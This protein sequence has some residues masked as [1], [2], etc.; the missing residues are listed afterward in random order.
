MGRRNVRV[1]VVVTLGIVLAMTGTPA[2]GA[3]GAA[4]NYGNYSMMAHQR[5]GQYVSDG[6]VVGL[7]SWSPQ[8]AGEARVAWVDQSNRSL[9]V[10]ERFVRSGNWVLLDGWWGNGAY[11]TQRVTRELIGD[12]NCRNMV[13]MPPDGGRLHYVQW[14]VPSEAY[15]LKA[16]GTIT[17]RSTGLVMQFGHT[18]VWHPPS[19]C[20]NPYYGRRTCIRQWESWW[21]NHGAPGAPITRKVQRTGWLARGVGMAFTVE[22][23]FPSSWRADL[24]RVWGSSQSREPAGSGAGTSTRGIGYVSSAVRFRG[25]GRRRGVR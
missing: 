19:T 12:A 15:C 14:S 6:E 13:A 3:P 17:D 11:Y 23:S 24:R 21:D 16:W 5:T 1:L 22:Q 8:L 7:W 25:A 18:Q 10:S 9:P 2:S 4:D 20:H